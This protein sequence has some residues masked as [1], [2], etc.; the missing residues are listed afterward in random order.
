MSSDNLSQ[1]TE[2]WFTLVVDGDEIPVH[3]DGVTEQDREQLRT[4]VESR[5][6][7]N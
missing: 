7:D 1:R 5:G 6:G 4:F 3:D 2:R